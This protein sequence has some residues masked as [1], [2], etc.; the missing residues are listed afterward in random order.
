MEEEG[1]TAL[2][3]SQGPLEL[4]RLLGITERTAMRYVAPAHPDRPAK[5]PR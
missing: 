3:D 1:L 5:L 2:G 4:M